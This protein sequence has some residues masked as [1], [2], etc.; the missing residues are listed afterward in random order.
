MKTKVFKLGRVLSFILFFTLFNVQ[1]NAQSSSACADCIENNTD[2]DVWV[3]ITFYCNGA[4]CTNNTVILIASNTTYCPTWPSSCSGCTTCDMEVELV[5]V[6]QN[7][8]YCTV[9]AP[10]KVSIYSNPGPI[11]P[12]VPAPCD[13]CFGQNL[14]M[15]HSGGLFWIG[16]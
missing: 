8:P 5:G 3:I 13:Q 4:P 11:T 15:K 1:A 2:C 14:V 9:A 12:G 6:D 7:P 10:N 16:L